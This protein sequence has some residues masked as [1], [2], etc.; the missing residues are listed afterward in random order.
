[1]I[2]VARGL[3]ARARRFN[4][5]GLATKTGFLRR[6]A[7]NTLKIAD[8]ALFSSSGCQTRVMFLLHGGNT[9]I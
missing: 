6:G 7:P 1:V 3:A 9:L 5:T 2:P 8:R 4:A